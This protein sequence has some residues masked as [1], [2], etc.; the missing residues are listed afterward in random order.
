MGLCRRPLALTCCFVVL[1]GPGE[2]SGATLQQ[3]SERA[4]A[5]TLNGPAFRT[6]NPW[7]PA[8]I[9]SHRDR[10]AASA[11]IMEH[12]GP[13]RKE[14]IAREIEN[15]R[16]QISR[17]KRRDNSAARATLAQ[18][19][20]E[21][22]ALGGGEE[23][24]GSRPDVQALVERQVEAEV[25]AAECALREQHALELAALRDQ[26]AIARE[27]GARA[28]QADMKEYHAHMSRAL[29]EVLGDAKY[30]ELAMRCR[31]YKMEHAMCN[32]KVSLV[33]LRLCMQ[34]NTCTHTTG[35]IRNV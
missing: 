23:D 14:A 18:L 3:R 29:F 27:D 30:E 8:A 21:L 16:A 10:A 32:G 9:G 20:E 12:D 1:F 24:L 22:S 28:F 4:C 13:S 34:E 19:S 31:I 5:S 25:E 33:L 35:L 6:A 26:I 15:L 11:G 17:N 7:S 2:P